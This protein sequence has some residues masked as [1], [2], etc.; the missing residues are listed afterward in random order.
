MKQQ[1]CRFNRLQER[2]NKGK[3]YKALYTVYVSQ[4]T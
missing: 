3:I 4:D 1:E 2:I